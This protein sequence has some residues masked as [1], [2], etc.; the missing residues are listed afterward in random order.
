LAQKGVSLKPIKELPG[1][2]TQQMVL[3]YPHL[4]QQNL[5]DAVTAL[6]ARKV[7]ARATT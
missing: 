1:H 3:R 6:D 2:S 7:E 4:Q 5:R